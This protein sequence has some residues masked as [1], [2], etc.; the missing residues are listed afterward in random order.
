M[1]KILNLYKVENWKSVAHLI[2]VEVE[3]K[4]Y[5]LM[6]RAEQG[7]PF[8]D[9]QIIEFLTML[10][11]AKEKY[12]LYINQNIP[13]SDTVT[14]DAIPLIKEN[15][16]KIEGEIETYLIECQTTYAEA[17]THY[18]SITTRSSGKSRDQS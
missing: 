13:I 9:D 14:S 5:R 6:R 3:D 12:A 18:D 16:K 2:P 10:R 4:Y 15:W 7:T 11:I 1:I 8:N 17:K